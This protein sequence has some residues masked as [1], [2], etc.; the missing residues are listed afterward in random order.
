MLGRNAIIQINTVTVGYATGFSMDLS[1]ET[2]KE[3]ALQSDQPAIFASGNKTLKFTMKR[4]YI[5]STYVNL[6]L[7][8]TAVTIVLGPAGTSV[9]NPKYTLTGAILDKSTITVDQKGVVGEDLA[10]E[11]LGI[12]VGSW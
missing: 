10:G 1:A 11:A 7:G 4:L 9:G 8:T 2:I 3:Y 12:T 6:F 5:D